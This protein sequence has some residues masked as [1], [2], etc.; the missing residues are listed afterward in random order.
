MKFN[1]SISKIR[2]PVLFLILLTDSAAL[3]SKPSDIILDRPV[4]AVEFIS[5]RTSQPNIT[6]L[7]AFCQ[8]PTN[9]FIFIK[10]KD[11]FFASYELTMTL[12]DLSGYEVV[13]A[14]L[15][16]SVEV[17]SFKDI[18]RPRPGRLTRFGFWLAPGEYE[19]RISLKDL[20]TLKVVSFKANV[21]VSAYNKT[22]LQLS[23]LQLATSITITDEHGAFVKNK[24]EV[25]PNVPGI[26]ITGSTDLY[27]YS[28]IYNFGYNLEE[29]NNE[30]TATYTIA[31]EKGKEIRSFQ[32]RIQKPGETCALSVK[33]PV[34]GFENGQ[35]ELI[36]N[37]ED[38]QSGQ[39]TQKRTNFVVLNPGSKPRIY[40]ELL[41]K[42]IL[43]MALLE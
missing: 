22:D 21:D 25:I 18:D 33:I 28:E 20:E 40:S 37:V 23:D 14:S 1:F 38:L 15:V 2:I 10:S 43:R 9:E 24:R 4:Y 7:E 30:F 6:Y 26:I 35:Y 32:R 16:D 12:Y 34:T 36:L 31:N 3:F 42:T 11:R 41:D 17:K 13:K 5:Y 19:S 27:V 39:S 29:L 8:I